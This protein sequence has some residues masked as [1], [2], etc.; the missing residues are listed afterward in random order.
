MV[1]LLK[2][3][4]VLHGRDAYSGSNAFIANETSKAHEFWT[5]YAGLMAKIIENLNEIEMTIATN[6]LKSILK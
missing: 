2:L 6:S 4:S 3:L 5:I 1:K